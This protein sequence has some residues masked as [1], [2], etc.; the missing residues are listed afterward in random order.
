MSLKSVQ[1][2]VWGL[3]LD[4]DYYYHKGYAGSLEQPPEPEWIELDDIT[5]LN[6]P[7]NKQEFL[8][9]G[10][11]EEELKNSDIFIEAV[12]QAIWDSFEYNKANDYDDSRD[13]SYLY[14]TDDIGW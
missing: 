3:D 8:D 6:T 4:V 5:F 12:E 11:T 2:S 1:I 10:W 9:S 7:E 13:D 14:D